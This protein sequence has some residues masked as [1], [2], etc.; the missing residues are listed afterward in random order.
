MMRTVLNS[1]VDDFDRHEREFVA[2]LHDRGWRRTNVFADEDGPGFTYTTRSGLADSSPI[3]PNTGGPRRWSD[4]LSRI[5][6][7]FS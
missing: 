3:S 1:P 5:D 6:A 7:H 4:D 2:D